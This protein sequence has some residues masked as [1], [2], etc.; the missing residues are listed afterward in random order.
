MHRCNKPAIRYSAPVAF[1]ACEEH[2]HLNR[3]R[4][5]LVKWLSFKPGESIRKDGA[6]PCDEPL[7]TR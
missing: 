1:R 7:S 3:E 4:W 2:Y 6:N 5:P